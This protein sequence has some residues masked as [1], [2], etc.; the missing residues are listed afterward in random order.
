M[1]LLLTIPGYVYL[2]EVLY[3]TYGI[4]LKMVM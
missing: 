1:L 4:I 2:G 3:E